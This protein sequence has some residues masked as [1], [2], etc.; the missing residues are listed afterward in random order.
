[1]SLALVGPFNGQSDDIVKK[2]HQHSRDESFHSFDQKGC[3]L[4]H[5][6]T[7]ILNATFA[8][9]H[10]PVHSRISVLPCEHDHGYNSDECHAP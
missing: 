10:G 9:D 7:T 3:E 1:M 8:V 4:S 5:N 2:N 6:F